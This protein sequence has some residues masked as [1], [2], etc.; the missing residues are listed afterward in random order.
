MISL[1]QNASIRIKA[2]A[3]PVVLLI[4]LV[5]LGGH[6][7]LTIGKSADGLEALTHK[8]LPKQ[9]AIS[10]LQDEVTT[11]H[12]ELF[13]FVT[14]V[15]NGVND[16][17]MSALSD[18]I[19]AHLL[20]IRKGLA[21][22]GARSDVSINEQ[23]IL[24]RLLSKWEKYVDAVND[25]LDVG[26][27]DA[28]MATM[29]LNA[30][31]DDFQKF[32]GDL[33][34]L[35]SQAGKQTRSA[36]V[37]LVATAQA[38]KQL[39][40]IG[41][42]V[43]TVL[44]IVIAVLVGRSIVKPV[45]AITRAMTEVSSGNVEFELEGSDRKDEVGQM[46][47]AIDLFRQRLQTQNTRLDAAL[48]NMSQGLCMFDARQRV[49]ICNERYA[50][51]Y[52]M[53]P[54]E[55]PPGT[56]LRDILSRR[57]AKGIYA[58]GSP[59]AYITEKLAPVLK[60]STL[61]QELTDGR[62]IL[63]SNQPMP[64]GG[65]VTTHEDISERRRAEK[66]IAYMALHDALTDLPNRVLLHER[67]KQ[68]LA[69]VRRGGRLAVMC[70]DLDHFKSV[71]DTCGHA[72]GDALLKAVA[73]RLRSCVRDNDTV[74]RLGG[75]EF[76][77][78][79]ATLERPEEAQALARRVR[80][81]IAAPY[82]LEG[83]Q[84][85]VDTSIGIAVAPDDGIESDDL[86]KNADMAAYAAK[87][88]GRG[89]YR[90][91]EPTMD[92]SLKARR[93]LE[94]DLRRALTRGEF[95][96]FY[97]PL[98]N[99]R[100]HTICHFEALLRWHHPSRGLIAAADFVPV[101]EEI[102]L[103]CPIGEWVIRTACAEASRWPSHIGVSVNLSPAQL[104]G[105]KLV[106][107]VVDALAANHVSAHRLELEVTELVLMQEATTTFSVLH[108]LHAIGVRLSI[109]DFGTGYSSFS[110]LRNFPF[111][112]IKIDRSFVAEISTKADSLAIVRA[113]TGLADS[114]K[115]TTAA[116]GIETEEQLELVKELGCTEVQGYL[117]SPPRPASELT[118]LLAR[119]PSIVAGAA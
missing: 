14:W 45:L 78:I 75:D 68:A 29:M 5:A 39:L 116:E 64:G 30:T 21:N 18:E 19:K 72:I 34:K 98:I 31:D 16:R 94:L 54:K 88:D 109:D 74:A 44:S 4:C 81:A 51:M 119:R 82:D 23:L 112:K 67:L 97:Q 3:A 101:A 115:M 22:F 6:A 100:E 91:F 73:D 47:K 85:V 55:I 76:A 15:S 108:Q 57:I 104:V 9:Q 93:A 42:T 17:L 96:L 20:A 37:D 35:S 70:L 2:F 107:T 69:K 114:L 66:Q 46:V 90:F 41:G 92:T 61:I 77:I 102:G 26:R 89:G 113:V 71:N 60:A 83:Q 95:E 32:A 56:A 33:Y 28:P 43:G 12:V 48:N 58:G 79:Q 103:I 11:T 13:R 8:S 84:V 86:M 10:E 25:T 52:H 24:A 110:H 117:F 53:L 36:A 111:D 62:A 63:V 27:T 99:L 65:W 1:I 118:K 105:D 50:R 38:N 87:A 80:E 59:E 40:A 49:I 106:P 7:Y